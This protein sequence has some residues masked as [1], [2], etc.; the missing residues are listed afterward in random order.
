MFLQVF[1]LRWKLKGELYMSV[2]SILGRKIGM[3][4]MFDDEGKSFA[5]TAVSAGPCTVTYL[6]NIDSDG[7]DSVQL[8]FEQSKTLNKPQ[9]GHLSDVDGVYSILR[10]VEPVEDTEN[11]IGDKVDSRM[12]SVGEKVSAMGYSKGRG[13]AGVVKR[14]GFKGGPKTHGQSDRHRAPGSIGAGSTPGRVLKGLRMAGHMGN[15]K[16]TVKNLEVIST[17]LGRNLLFLKGALPGAKNSII[18]LTKNSNFG[19]LAEE[20]PVVETSADETPVDETPVVEAP[21]AEAPVVETPAEETPVAEAPVVE[22]P[23]EGEDK[24]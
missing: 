20:A 1:S 18:L 14:H 19:F 8:G 23:A 13:F 11:N 9:S 3:T 15:Q 2:K 4:A 17:D 24:K 16:V 21:V 12:F 7:Y 22:T 5:V 10:E 6:K